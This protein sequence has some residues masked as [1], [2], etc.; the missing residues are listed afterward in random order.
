[1]FR[2]G[3]V[4]LLE[5]G[6]KR[7]LSSSS[8]PHS[9][10]FAVSFLGAGVVS[11]SSLA[12]S[13]VRLR[14]G[15]RSQWFRLSGRCGGFSPDIGVLSF[16]PLLCRNALCD[17]LLTNPPFVVL[18]HCSTLRPLSSYLKVFSSG[19][20]FVKTIR[21][22]LPTLKEVSSPSPRLLTF[23]FTMPQFVE[24]SWAEEGGGRVGALRLCVYFEI[25]DPL[26]SLA[27]RGAMVWYNSAEVAVSKL[28]S[29][30]NN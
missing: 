4:F 11:C 20:G 3:N 8:W 13:Y 17:E 2:F 24:G 10:T 19:Y 12:F 18:R 22:F 29:F 26:P 27:C 1:M 9:F 25:A 16:L 7:P 30:S 14:G 15:R 6:D 21:R 28:L 23:C 5:S